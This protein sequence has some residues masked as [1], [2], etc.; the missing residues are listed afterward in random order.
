MGSPELHAETE[1]PEAKAVTPTCDIVVCSGRSIPR[2]YRA[3]VFSNWLRSMR[4][5][6]DFMRSTD[7]KPYYSFYQG[8]I[9][10]ILDN[11]TCDVRFLV[12]SEDHDVILGFACTRDNT[13]D[14]V[15]VHKDFRR[16]GLAALLTGR[17]PF[18]VV[19]AMTKT[20]YIITSHMANPPTFNPF[21]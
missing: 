19:T 15:F 20:G 7:S 5:G 8:R 10:A 14:Y 21:L 9:E 3:Y 18:S 6:C 2:A 1:K 11:P 4:Y 12:L 17:R 16:S 13:L